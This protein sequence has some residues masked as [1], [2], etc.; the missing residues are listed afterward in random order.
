[1]TIALKVMVLVI[2]MYM[3]CDI[4][5]SLMDTRSG[6]RVAIPED[7][8]PK[9][10]TCKTHPTVVKLTHSGCVPKLVRTYSC[11]GRCHSRAIPEWDVENE[12]VHM[13]EHCT[14]CKPMVRAMRMVALECPVLGKARNMLV[15]SAF[16]CRCR[17]CSEGK[18]K[19][20]KLPEDY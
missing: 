16:E 14:C 20:F 9:P 11:R 12:Q 13:I 1:M 10:E 7:R 5:S 6:Q 19:P 2:T 17:P 15:R 3:P 8:I 18:P 4:L